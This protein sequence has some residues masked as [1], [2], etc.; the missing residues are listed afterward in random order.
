MRSTLRAFNTYVQCQKRLYAFKLTISYLQ[1]GAFVTY[2]HVAHLCI[3]RLVMPLRGD[4]TKSCFEAG[5]RQQVND[6]A[7]V[8]HPPLKA[9]AK[10]CAIFASMLQSCNVRE[11]TP[12][13]GAHV[14]THGESSLTPQGLGQVCT[15]ALCQSRIPPQ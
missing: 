6:C 7:C 14:R 2:Y 5:P 13:K 10:Q 11:P 4:P 15:P 9:V 1:S 3:S 8:Y 12:H